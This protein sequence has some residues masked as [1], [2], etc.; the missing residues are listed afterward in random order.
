MFDCL[1]DAADEVQR[2]RRR[3]SVAKIRRVWVVRS[4][5]RGWPGW[6]YAFVVETLAS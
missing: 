3:G 2:L 5:E 4:N 6:V 1:F